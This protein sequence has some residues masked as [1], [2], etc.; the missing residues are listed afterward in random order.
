MLFALSEVG[1]QKNCHYYGVS[2]F[3]SASRNRQQSLPHMQ[4]CNFYT[5]VFVQNILMNSGFAVKEP[6]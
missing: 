1:L 2:F 5:S 4:S 3:E 6:E